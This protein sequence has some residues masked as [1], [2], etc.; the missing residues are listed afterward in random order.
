MVLLNRKFSAPAATDKAQWR[1]VEFLV[2]HGFVFQTVYE[3]PRGGKAVSYPATLEEAK[4]FVVTYA[5]Q[6]VRSDA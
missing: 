2:E 3:T 6:A 4:G 5:A 1:K